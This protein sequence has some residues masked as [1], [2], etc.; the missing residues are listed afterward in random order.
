MSVVQVSLRAVRHWR[1]IVPFWR[2]TWGAIVAIWAPS[3]LVAWSF[4]ASLC[5]VE[6]GL[7]GFEG[8][9][10]DRWLRRVARD[11]VGAV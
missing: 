2:G 4:D 5:A 8:P 10:S 3:S 1:S 9:S 7:V 6:L 11:F